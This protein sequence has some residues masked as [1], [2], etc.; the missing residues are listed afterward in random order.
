MISID[1]MMLIERNAIQE[2]AKS[3]TEEDIR[4]LVEWLS[5][6]D[7]MIRYQAFQLLQKRS[8]FAED[9]Y[10]HWD[11]FRNKLKSDNS[12]QRSIGLMLIAE[13]AKWDTKDKLE[14]TI[15]E[16]L[17]LLHDEKP[18]TIRQCVQSIAKIIP[19]KPELNDIIINNLISLDLMAIRETMRKSILTDILNVLFIIRKEYP[20]DEI[21][22]YIMNALSGGILDKKAKRLFQDLL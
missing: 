1:S 5:L 16:H 19:F 14:E 3:L 20:S 17:E 2:A 10:L 9:V 4:Q 11:I 22:H 13:N 21:D 18:I 15:K 12:Y 7:D 6:K 8:E